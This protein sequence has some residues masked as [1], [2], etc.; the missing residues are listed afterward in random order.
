MTPPKIPEET[1]RATFQ[2][3]RFA[4]RDWPE[5][6]AD[7]MADPIIRR[8]IEIL[9]RQDVAAIARKKAPRFQMRGLS[10]KDHAAGERDDD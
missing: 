2:R 10:G 5:S 6:F 3:R 1:L 4:Y 9:A 8:L 7:A